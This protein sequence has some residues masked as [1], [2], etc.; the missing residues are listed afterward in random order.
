MLSTT[1]GAGKSNTASTVAPYMHTT[2]CREA[3]ALIRG[4]S[5][6][7]YVASLKLNILNQGNK[8]TFVIHNK[9]DVTDVY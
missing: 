8:H 5:I 9:K 7:E 3:L 4:A 1:A 2:L 6:M